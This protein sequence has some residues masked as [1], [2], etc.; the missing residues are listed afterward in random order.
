[1]RWHKLI[2]GFHAPKFRSKEWLKDNRPE[3]PPQLVENVGKYAAN[4]PQQAIVMPPK[5]QRLPA[6]RLSSECIEAHIFCGLYLM[7]H[8]CVKVQERKSSTRIAKH[9]DDGEVLYSRVDVLITSINEHMVAFVFCEHYV[10]CATLGKRLHGYA[11][12]A[13]HSRLTFT[14]YYCRYRTGRPRSAVPV[15]TIGVLD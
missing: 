9:L 10:V 1:M 7:A 2:Q 6:A 15:V 4:N 5:V 3:W 14:L 8:L 13:V 12:H 11:V